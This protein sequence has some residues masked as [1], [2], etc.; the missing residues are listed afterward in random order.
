[1]PISPVR[2]I[3]ALSC[4]VGA[5]AIVVAQ[6]PPLAAFDV[7]EK[8]IPELQ[9]AMQTGKVTSKQLTAI[10]LA[11]I[12]AYDREG[13]RINSMIAVNPHAL[14]AA[15]ALD[16]ERQSRGPRGPLHGIPVV[17]KD[18]YETADM[19]TT[20]GSLALA[21]METH[22]D[23]F[24][25]RKLRDAGAVIVGKTNLHELASGITTISSMGG[26][27]LN[28]YGLG[29]NPGGSS[30][31]TGA[32]VA[33]NFAVAGM[34]SDT[35]GSIRNPASHNNLFGLRGTSGLSSRTGIVPLSHTQDIGG[36][37]ARSVIDLAIM[38]D[39][40]VGKDPDDAITATSDGH[41][42]SSYRQALSTEALKGARIGVLTSLF[43]SAPEDQEVATIV[44]KAVEAM[45]QA[46]AETIDVTVPGLDD[47]LR[48]SSVINAE[49]KFDLMDYLA[50]VPGAP[51]KSLGEILDSGR[52]HAS[53]DANFKARNRP[54]SRETDEYRRALIKRAAV[55][56]VVL[57]SID[58]HRLDALVY[59][60]LRRKPSWVGEAQG[61][62]N[63]QLSP[64][65]GL[66]AI[67]VPAGFTDD[68]LPIGMDLL[69]GAFA[70]PKLLSLA[71]AYEH[72]THPRRPPAST[73][74]LVN[75]K[76][77][78][79]ISLSATATDGARGVTATFTF[80]RLT[81]RLG[82]QVSSTGL[83]PGVTAVATLHRGAA[84]QNGPVI[85]RLMDGASG[86]G[87]LDL[88]PVD[89]EALREGRLYLEMIASGRSTARL[90]TQ[91]AL[92]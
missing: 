3:A 80:D 1:M 43:G 55:R 87:A 32:A 77:P 19:P 16:R 59:P 67:G 35:C 79:M 62:S 45:K 46:G 68:G 61:G 33:S 27:T 23:A 38:L 66:P 82:Y 47:L 21:G 7:L 28:P 37:L 41:I 29:R 88:A 42:P 2:F 10:Y 24:Q 53:L 90:R 17:V 48:G 92:T 36:P 72:A 39:A 8:S 85:S 74:A 69:G 13:P 30:G 14:E 89:R 25:V 76:A 75:G 22:R 65:A 81:G 4:A 40:T 58:E 6:S 60:T 71:Y 20:A 63:C 86:S 73:P 15:E 49:F 18:N 78:G 50:R 11:R 54:E 31:G 56:Q 26:Q 70:E 91:I 5:A 83:G 44:K 51:L 57:A 12:Q 52:Y 34:G 64:S 9:E 84:G